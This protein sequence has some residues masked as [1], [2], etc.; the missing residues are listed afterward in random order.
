M[1]NALEF[2]IRQFSSINQRHPLTKNG[3]EY[4][5]LLESVGMNVY[6]YNIVG[7]QCIASCSTEYV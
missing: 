4:Y 5:V 6:L 2:D 3:C 7:F 1:K